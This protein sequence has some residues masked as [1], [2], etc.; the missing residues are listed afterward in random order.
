MRRR[1]VL[2]RFASSSMV[3]KP[4]QR[5]MLLLARVLAASRLTRSAGDDSSRRGVAHG[6]MT[7]V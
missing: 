5:L 7:C 4:R 1:G 3:M 6:L 2:F